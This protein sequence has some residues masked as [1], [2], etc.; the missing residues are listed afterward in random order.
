MK[1]KYKTMRLMVR[2]RQAWLNK[3]Y[4]RAFAVQMLIPEIGQAM[5][6]REVEE[7]EEYSMSP[8]KGE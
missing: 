7:L 4:N 2:I 3:G 8:K 5:A 1:Y 6:E